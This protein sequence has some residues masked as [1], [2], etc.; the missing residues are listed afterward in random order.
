MGFM[1]VFGLAIQTKNQMTA[2]IAQF[3]KES[4]GKRKV[5]SV[6]PDRTLQAQVVHQMGYG[7]RSCPGGQPL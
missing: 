5:W 1:P 7:L 6:D 2:D 4:L 3:A